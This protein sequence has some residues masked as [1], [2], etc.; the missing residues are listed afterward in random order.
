M[1]LSIACRIH[2]TWGIQV[3]DFSPRKCQEV[4]GQI[5]AVELKIGVG[6]FE[7]GEEVGTMVIKILPQG[8][9]IASVAM[10]KIPTNL[11]GG[12][13]CHRSSREKLVLFN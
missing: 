6:T 8:G 1:H 9:A 2:P 12:G 10:D 3:D 7:Q 11:Q 4:E 13:A 5:Y